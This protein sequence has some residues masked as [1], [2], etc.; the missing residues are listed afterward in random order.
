MDKRAE[1]K[2]RKEKLD[3]LNRAGGRK[4]P[5]PRPAVFKDK[6]KYDRNRQKA[7]NRRY[8]MA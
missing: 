8:C 1:K 5:M 2:K 7:E 6:S 3:M 4:E